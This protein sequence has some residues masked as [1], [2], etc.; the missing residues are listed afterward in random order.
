MKRYTYIYNNV[1]SLL[2][3]AV[4]TTLLA[5]LAPVGAQAQ[6]DIYFT[7]CGVPVTNSNADNI[8]IG[9]GYASYNVSS[10]TLYLSDITF[11]GGGTTTFLSFGNND[12]VIVP[13]DDEEFDPGNM[14]ALSRGNRAMEASEGLTIQVRYTNTFTNMATGIDCNKAIEIVPLYSEG[15]LNI[16]GAG[17]MRNGG[18]LTIAGGAKVTFESTTGEAV[19]TSDLTIGENSTLTMKGATR[20]FTAKHQPTLGTDIIV[21]MP[22]VSIRNS[23]DGWTAM[24]STGAAVREVTIG[25]KA[26]LDPEL[27]FSSNEVTLRVGEE[28]GELPVLNNPHN[29]PITWSLTCYG[30]T[31]VTVDANGRLSLTGNTGTN[32]IYANFAGN[33]YYRSGY[34]RYY[35]EVKPKALTMSFPQ[36]TY[37]AYLGQD[38]E[39]PQLIAPEDVGEIQYSVDYYGKSYAEVDE[40]TGEVTLK[41]TGEATITAKH[42]ADDKYDEA[43]AQY[44]LKIRKPKAPVKWGE[45]LETLNVNFVDDG[46]GHMTID[47]PVLTS[48]DNNQLYVNCSTTNLFVVDKAAGTFQLYVNGVGIHHVTA[49]YPEDDTYENTVVTLTVNVTDPTKLTP[50]LNFGELTSYT[51]SVTGKSMGRAAA[52]VPE[53]NNPENLDV[54]WSITPE[55][56]GYV[57]SGRI[58]DEKT[59]EHISGMCIFP[60]NTGTGML[61]ASFQGNATYNPV[62]ASIPLYILR[63]VELEFYG[64]YFNGTDATV[65]TNGEGLENLPELSNPEGVP[66]TFT[67]SNVD[68]ATIDATTGAVTPLAAGTTTITAA[69]AGNDECA[70]A[71]VS[72][73]LIVVQKATATLSFSQTECEVKV[74]GEGMDQLPTLNNVDGVAVTYTSSNESVATVNATTGEVTLKGGGRTVITAAFA[75]DG[76]LDASSA[77]YTLIVSK[78][79]AD[80]SLTNSV[81]SISMDGEE[82]DVPVLNNP[83][84]VPV[85]YTSSDTSV[86]T[87]DA[88]TGEPTPVSTGTTTISIT[89]EGTE[90]YEARTISYTLSVVKRQ[91]PISFDRNIEGNDPEYAGYW[92][93]DMDGKGKENLPQ[94]V[95][96]KNLPV[97][98]YSDNEA[99][100]TV[101]ATGDITP[102]CTGQAGIYVHFLGNEVYDDIVLGYKVNIGLAPINNGTIDVDLTALD[103][104]DMSQEIVAGGIYLNLHD[105]DACDGGF[106]TIGQATDMDAVGNEGPGSEAV[107]NNFCGIIIKVP[108]GKGAVEVSAKTEGNMLLAVKIG[109]QEPTIVSS[110]TADFVY[111]KYNVAVETNI[112]IYAVEGTATSRGVNR[113]PGEGG[114]VSIYG[115]SVAEFDEESRLAATEVA[116]YN[117][118]QIDLPISLNS[119]AHGDN[120]AGV[121][122]N[123]ALPEGV[124][125]VLDSD[126]EPVCTLNSSRLSDKFN[127]MTSKQA[128]GSWS[129]RI[130]TT[131]TNA[132]VQ[133]TE[134]T[135]LTLKVNVAADMAAGEYEVKLADSKLSVKD[136]ENN[137][138]TVFI[139]ETA[140]KFTVVPVRKGDVNRDTNVDLSDAIMVVYYLLGSTPSKFYEP[141][142]DISG[143]GEVGIEDVTTIIYTDMGVYSTSRADNNVESIN[144]RSNE[145]AAETPAESLSVETVTVN[146]GGESTFNV[147][148]Q[149]PDEGTY[150]GFIFKVEL[151]EGLSLVTDPD[152]D[153]A[154]WYDEDVEA[155]SKM[156]IVATAN[157]FAATPKKK[158]STIVGRSGV[159]MTLK[160]KADADLA[161]GEHQCK[162]TN[163]AFSIRDEEY[164]VTKSQLADVPFTVNGV[165]TG[166][167][168]ID[169]N[170]NADAPAFTPDGRRADR[171]TKGIV[172]INGQKVFRR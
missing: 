126:D 118:N 170:R 88:A 151:P 59:G 23:A 40:H 78:L 120:I 133:L 12:K 44:T 134:G 112:Y 158:A 77:S 144:S 106:I 84:N 110:P 49:S 45:G 55:D 97:I 51:V 24:N 146:P 172:I 2:V 58:T 29:L 66:V 75:G 167:V 150:V 19:T 63:G 148:F 164:N 68:V 98:F 122:F 132:T 8:N 121:S 54:E 1:K 37:T 10:N 161:T 70:P 156:N 34:A 4:L 30:D 136:N 5:W 102:V 9:S 162:L 139:N 92:S 13:I 104:V 123:I 52:L 43:E 91:A 163:V 74:N 20:A 145:P 64:Y 107:R 61:I 138:K 67:S 81:G 152:D 46:S 130:Y 116:T 56:L 22:G 96:P 80:L 117:D 154:A 83:N 108:A 72:Y 39:E 53:L 47:L 21:L 159:L 42:Y 82:R 17:C 93:V 18:A 143:D 36:S 100:V 41:S 85:G 38:F 140:T 141:A 15:A 166:I 113:A 135:L 129:F 65:Y 90:L 115:L 89:F 99:V 14:E 16:S 169:A 73:T 147:N 114:S 28:L 79:D 11:D 165:V 3:T 125:A 127:V 111:V 27:S 137:V 76:T 124:T 50:V 48:P 128:D 25:R 171:T 57:R 87:V 103:D 33:D 60:Y 109:N 101:D 32:A 95:N 155:I 26:S 149:L 160:V 86:A 153:E 131:A 119:T 142:A 69:F 157:G 6:D 105:A 94:L 71:S 168:D 7:F 35:V 62:Q 31:V